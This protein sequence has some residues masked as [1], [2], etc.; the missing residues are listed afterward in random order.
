[1]D[2]QACEVLV[3]VCIPFHRSMHQNALSKLPSSPV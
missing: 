1:L 3:K 2:H